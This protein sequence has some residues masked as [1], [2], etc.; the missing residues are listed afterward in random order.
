METVDAVLAADV[1]GLVISARSDYGMR[2]LLELTAAYSRD[3]EELVKAEVIAAAQA[4][5]S[6]FLEGILTQLR[7]EGLVHS[8]RGRT[9]GFRLARPPGRI[10]LAEIMGALHAPM[11]GFRSQRREDREYPGSAAHLADVWIAVRSAMR[12][13]LEAVTLADLASGQLPTEVAALLRRKDPAAMDTD[14]G[15][16]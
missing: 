8:L 7:R 4:I 11:V 13:V 14:E 12:T 1:P 9:G 16:A 10:N 2:A 3:P 15:S 6:K 5:P